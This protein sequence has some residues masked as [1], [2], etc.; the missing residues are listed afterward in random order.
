MIGGK[1]SL[2]LNLKLLLDREAIVWYNYSQILGSFRSAGNVISY[3][4]ID[5]VSRL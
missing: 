1:A 3:Y 5:I 2:N 4:K